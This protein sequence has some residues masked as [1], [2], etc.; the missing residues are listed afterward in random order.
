MRVRWQ[1]GTAHTPP[2]ELPTCEFK[3]P[4]S[5]SHLLFAREVSYVDSIYVRLPSREFGYNLIT[6]YLIQGYEG[7]KCVG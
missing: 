5:Y 6:I 2:L 3:P 4:L 7:M 1:Q